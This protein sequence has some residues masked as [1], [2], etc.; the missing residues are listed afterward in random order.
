[1]P[2]FCWACLTRSQ[3]RGRYAVA[4]GCGLNEDEF[5]MRLKDLGRLFQETYEQWSA[6]KAPRLG[7]ALAYYSVFSI[8]PLLILVIAAAGMLFGEDAA[9]GVV[10]EEIQGFLGE[11]AAAA[12]E[13][14]IQHA[15]QDNS[16][17]LLATLLA[18]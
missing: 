6:D 16:A 4:A 18:S 5:I 8:A 10:Q 14:M 12:I 7:A 3:R 9:R 17:S 2:P 11:R 13:E 15:A 1:M